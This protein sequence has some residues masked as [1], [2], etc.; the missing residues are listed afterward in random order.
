MR[1][2]KIKLN[3]RFV[4]LCVAMCCVAMTV[5]DSTLGAHRLTCCRSEICQNHIRF[6]LFI[7]IYINIYMTSTYR[8]LQCVAVCVAVCLVDIHLS[9]I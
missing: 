2:E 3:Q 1:C 5:V 8:Q 7:C 6:D 4:A 9:R